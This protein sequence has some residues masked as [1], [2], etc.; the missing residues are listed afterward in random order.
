MTVWH[1]VIQE[2][3]REDGAH[4]PLGTSTAPWMTVRRRAVQLSVNDL[5]YTIKP[6]EL[7]PYLTGGSWWWTRLRPP[8]SP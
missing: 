3:R 8:T 4:E 5:R 7:A 2:E 1:G 6:G